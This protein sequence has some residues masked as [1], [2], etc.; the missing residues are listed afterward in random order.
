MLGGTAVSLSSF[1]F[2]VWAEYCKDEGLHYHILLV[3]SS[4]TQ[5]WHYLDE[6]QRTFHDLILEIAWRVPKLLSGE[7]AK[8]RCYRYLMHYTGAK[9]IDLW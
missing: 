6:V 2:G 1:G 8:N 5:V 7:D 3:C 9:Y 4:R